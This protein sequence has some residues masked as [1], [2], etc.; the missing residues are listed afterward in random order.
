[1]RSAQNVKKLI[2][3]AAIDSNSEVDEMVLRGLLEELDKSKSTDS[4]AAQPSIRRTIMKSRITK[5]TA[6]AVIIIAVFIG[7]D[8]LGGIHPSAIAWADVTRRFAQVDYVHYHQFDCREDHIESASEGWYSRGKEV[9]RIYDGYMWYDDGQTLQAFDRHNTR[10]VKTESRFAD[11]RSFFEMI[12]GGL[13]SQDNEQ[14]KQQVPDEVGDDFLVY[15]FPMKEGIDYNEEDGALLVSI[16]VGR[17]SLLPA[18]IKGYYRQMDWYG[19]RRVTSEGQVLLILDYEAS[20]KPAEFFEPP[21]ESEPP[22]G[23]GEVVLDGEEVVIDIHGA[24]GIKQAIVRLH[25]KYEG[26]SDQIRHIPHREKYEEQ[27]GPVF[28]LDV[29]FVTEEGYRS[30]TNDNI[31]LWLNEGSKCGVGAR[32][33]PDGKYRNIRF[34]P[35]LKATEQEGVYIVEVSCWVRTKDVNF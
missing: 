17:N 12:S 26:P 25:D 34:T 22:H 31:L 14:F 8:Y 16:T 13:L 1:M 9:R 10:T 19:D 20:E 15:R 21:T 7:V 29:T 2:K 18:Q 33:W 4:A 28:R 32:N 23:T 30:I 5:L 6:A 11:G 35:V 27:G 24:P 3:N